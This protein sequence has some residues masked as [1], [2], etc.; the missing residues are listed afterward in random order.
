MLYSFLNRLKNNQIASIKYHLV[1]NLS[2]KNSESVIKRQTES[3]SVN[4]A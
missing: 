1:I 2:K 3:N 4:M